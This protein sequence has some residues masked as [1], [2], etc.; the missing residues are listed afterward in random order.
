MTFSI[1][2]E[3]IEFAAATGS[4]VNAADNASI[5]DNP[6]NGFKDLVITTNPGDPEPRLFEIGDTYDLAWG[7]HGGSHTIE[8]ATVVRSDAA[9]GGGGI[10]VFEGLNDVGALTQIIWTP[11]FDLE[12]WYWSTY[13][14]IAEPQFYT[15]D[16]NPGYTHGHICFAAD[17]L[18]AGPHG[19]M[20][21]DDIAPGDRVDTLDSGMQTVRW[22]GRMTVPASG[23]AAPIRFAPGTIGNDGPLRLSPQHRVL[24]RSERAELLFGAPEVLVPAKAM[25]NGAGISVAPAPSITYV[26]LLLDAHELLWADG[27]LCESLYLGDQTQAILAGLSGDDPDRRMIDALFR[28]PRRH[29]RPARPLLTAR[30][31]RALLGAPPPPAPVPCRAAV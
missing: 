15:T 11:G 1:H 27:A 28:D 24:I 5:F 13:N 23:G 12:N 22:A 21:A 4:N 17:T 18:I 25:V 3:D 14:P 9:P 8:N 10:V 16:T 19:P 2:A 6:P 29:A 30:E 7:G 26:H 20:R 31:A